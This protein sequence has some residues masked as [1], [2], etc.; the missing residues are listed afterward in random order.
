MD[1]PTRR[2]RAVSLPGAARLSVRTRL[3][4]LLC[5]A[6]LLPMAI[7]GVLETR[8][9][10]SN[11]AADRQDELAE[12]A[13]EVSATADRIMG[14]R[15]GDTQAFA[16]SEAARSMRPGRIAGWRSGKMK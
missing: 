7:I 6:G 9:A 4:A 2:A 1:L 15:F 12:A 11:L 14:E 8:N 13:E 16:R 5:A 10:S 3:L